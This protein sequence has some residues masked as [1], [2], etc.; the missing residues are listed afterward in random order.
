[1]TTEELIAQTLAGGDASI[2]TAVTSNSGESLKT[3]AASG[4]YL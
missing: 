3:K 1:M 2:N 4:T